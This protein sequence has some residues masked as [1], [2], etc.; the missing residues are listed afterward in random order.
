MSKV[1]SAARWVH[2]QQVRRAAVAFALSLGM[3]A[4]AMAAS[5][6]DQPDPDF[7]G[8]V[9]LTGAPAVAGSEAAVAGR[10]FKPGQEITLSSGGVVLNDKAYVADAEGGF[11]GKVAIPKDATVGLHPVVVEVAKPSAAVVF[12]LKV[13]P[14]L[15]LSG[16]DA[17]TV[18]SGKAAQGV[19]QSSYSPK[20][21]ALYIT[22]AVGR[23]P[24]KVSELLKVN[25]KTLAVDAR[26]TPAKVP[27]RDD[28][29]VFAVYGVGV[30]DANGNVWTTNTRDNTVAVYKQSDLSLVKQ[31]DAKQVNHARDVIV[32]EKAGKAYASATGTNVVA[33]FDSKKV[34]FLKNIEIA[35]ATREAFSAGSLDL[36]R[37]A[38]KLYVVSLSTN[39]VAII[40]TK[41]DTVEKV[42]PLEGARS[43]IG[44]AFDPKTNRV[45]VA[46]QGSDN[47]LIADA[48]T[49]KTLHN[50][51]TGAGA[52]NVAFDPVGRLAYVAN[53]GAG[54]VTVVDPD[55]KV[56]ANLDGGSLPNHVY[57]D[58]K[59]N[60]YLVNKARGQ[61]DAT[62]DRI[63]RITQKR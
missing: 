45:F 38:H 60:V 13:S 20:G 57:A 50:V 47:L 11:Q 34:D 22:T 17:F 28:D 23:P 24:I 58:G 25:A 15:A 5:T 42:F 39:E 4:V 51:P 18:T 33:A 43:A 61:D 10:G 49:G 31:F 32:D 46:A 12:N 40:D 29:H 6:F 56:V 7:K 8:R 26:I 35:S 27:G 44:I 14:N 62:G 16:Q 54:T 55:G 9:M 41:T 1:S 59:G 30:D 63:S 52:L 53:R 37:A 19:Y 3:S 48:A 21:D 36:D 2:G